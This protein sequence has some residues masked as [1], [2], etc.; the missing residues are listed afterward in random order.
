MGTN[1][2]EILKQLPPERRKKI[3]E[4]SAELIAEEMTRQR[5]RQALNI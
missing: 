5:I 2:E 3:E 1:L 4:R